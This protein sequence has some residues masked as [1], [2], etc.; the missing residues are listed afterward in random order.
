MY[1]DCWTVG[2]EEIWISI[3][4]NF[5]QKVH[6]SEQRYNMFFH[7]NPLFDDVL[8]TNPKTRFHSCHWDQDCYVHEDHTVSIHPTPNKNTRPIPQTHSRQL[9]MTD[10]PWDCEP[11]EQMVL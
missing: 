2:Y 1:L 5:G 4:E 7:M 6:V 10:L 11:L 9:L 8:T 3:T